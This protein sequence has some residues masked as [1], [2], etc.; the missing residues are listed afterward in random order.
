MPKNFY[1]LNLKKFK[2]KLINYKILQEMIQKQVYLFVY[3]IQIELNIFFVNIIKHLDVDHVQKWV[4][5]NQIVKLQI[6]LQYK[7]QKDISKCYRKNNNM[8]YQKDLFQVEDFIDKKEFFNLVIL[9][10]L[11]LWMIMMMIIKMKKMKMM[12]VMNI[13][14]INDLHSQRY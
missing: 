3:F 12:I 10:I 5:Q 8:I 4:I 2:N 7:I 11:L 9:W 6:Y 14:R 1:F 13:T